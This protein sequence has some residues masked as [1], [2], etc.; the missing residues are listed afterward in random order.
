MI[1]DIL[2]KRENFT[3]FR[4][5]KIP[6]E[7]M[8]REILDKAHNLTPHKNNFWH[9]DI[10]VFGPEQVETKRK[11]AMSTVCNDHKNHYRKENLTDKD[12]KEL[13]KNYQYWLDLHDGDKSKQYVEDNKWFFNEQVTAP[14]LIAYYPAKQ[15]LRESQKNTDYFK[16]G[17]MQE[18][19]NDTAK[20][21]NDEFNHQ[22]GMHALVTSMLALEKDI[23]VSFCRC[24]FYHEKI[25]T[26]VLLK[27]GL[28]FL[29]GL[30]YRDRTKKNY[31]S[32][33]TKP[34]FDEV[35]KWV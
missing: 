25:H 22:A 23:D 4:K 20:V 26:D 29:L 21:Y 33:V 14:Y 27:K 6:E 12:W 16:G 8:V 19:F 13:E 10:Y 3:F 9:Y 35:V 18:V 24:Y 34:K 17:R 30:G 32:R 5:D 31:K 1:E 15:K 11:L 28:P 2:K 7:S